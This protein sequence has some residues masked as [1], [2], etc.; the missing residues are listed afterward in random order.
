MTSSIDV[1]KKYY[2]ENCKV[3]HDDIIEYAYK[4]YLPLIEKDYNKFYFKYPKEIYEDASPYL[5]QL[6]QLHELKKEHEIN[7]VTKQPVGLEKYTIA[8]LEKWKVP[9]DNLMFTQNKD[10]IR[11]DVLVDDYTGNL[12]NY[13]QGIPVCLDRPW[14]KEW[15]G[16]RIK[17][18]SELIKYEQGG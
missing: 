10:L 12:E 9:Y 6:N 8:W 13:K 11:G 7:I 4:K 5:K 3:V 15:K 1:Y 18:L 17:S 14:N 16:E 2:D